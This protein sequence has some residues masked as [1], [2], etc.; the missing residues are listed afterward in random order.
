MNINDNHIHDFINYSVDK[1]CKKEPKNKNIGDEVKQFY[2]IF[3]ENDPLKIRSLFKNAVPMIDGNPDR[4][5][6][7]RLGK[8]FYLIKDKGFYNVFYQVIDILQ[9]T[10]DM[11]HVIRGSSG[12]SVICYL[13]GITHIDPIKNNISLARFMHILRNDMPDIDI[14]FPTHL[15]EEVYARIFKKYQGRVARISNHVHYGPKTA[16]KQALR[17]NGIKGFISKDFNYRKILKE[18]LEIDDEDELYEIEK[19]VLD[20]AGIYDGLEKHTSLHCGGIFITENAIPEDLILHEIESNGVK[21]FQVKLDKDETEDFGFIKIDILSNRGLSQVM[22]IYCDLEKKG[23]ELPNFQNLPIESQVMRSIVQNNIGLTYAESRGMHKIFQRLNPNTIDDISIALA[24]IRPAASANGQ[25]SEYLRSL[26]QPDDPI[27]GDKRPWVIYDDDAI[28]YIQKLIN[29]DESQ[30]DIYRK[31]FS[32]S[33]EKTVGKRKEFYKRMVNSKKYTAEQIDEVIAQLDCLQEYGFCKSHSYSYAYLVYALAYLKYHFPKEFWKSTLNYCN[34]SFRS[35]VHYR[36]AA[37]HLQLTHMN[38]PYCISN[39]GNNLLPLKG[40]TQLRLFANCN[41]DFY[42][43]GYWCSKE[44][45]PGMYFIINTVKDK[46]KV[47]FRGIVATYRPYYDR[48]PQSKFKKITFITL[49]YD[50]GKYLDIVVDGYYPLSHLPIVKGHGEME[51][52]YIT[53]TKITLEKNFTPLKI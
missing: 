4:R 48:S 18:R 35:W 19:K 11:I 34:S 15:R 26:Q 5:Y 43:L 8:E 3:W 12:S 1:M 37:M 45:M 36:E 44:F 50:N 51:G 2:S 13:T 31:A 14:D 41:N 40:G 23:I 46:K 28:V 32:K 9:L 20:E 24:L 49:G 30:A 33:S 16:L 42:K 21:A 52:D 47:S 22:D 27:T 7:R 25:K 17:N 10:Q 39:H 53:C 6:L 29:I 38:K